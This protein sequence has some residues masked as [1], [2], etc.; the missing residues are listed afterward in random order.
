MTAKKKPHELNVCKCPNCDKNRST[1][2]EDYLPE[3]HIGRPTKYDAKKTPQRA[4]ELLEEGKALAN[5]CREFQITPETLAQWRKKYPEFSEA[6]NKGLAYSNAWWQDQARLNIKSQFFK[7][8][9]WFMNM[10]NR[11]KWNDQRP[12]TPPQAIPNFD[13]SLSEKAKALDVAMKEGKLSP[14]VYTMIMQSL[15]C[16]A[17]IIE[18]SDNQEQIAVINKKLGL[19]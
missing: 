4:I 13:G 17:K 10:K 8:K 12:I 16:E 14:D 19:K 1:K 3:R 18:V 6:I 2:L 11:F 5:L 7:E 9:L 15:S